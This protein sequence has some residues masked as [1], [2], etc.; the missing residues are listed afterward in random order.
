MI[1]RMLK[2]WKTTVGG[3]V[4]ILGGLGSIGAGIQKA[5]IEGDVTTGLGLI[6]IGGA[7][8]GKGIALLFAKDSN[9]TG[10]TTPNAVVEG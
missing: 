3:I 2:N 1:K 9:V 7:A 5:V 6:S 8:I 10:G 4:G